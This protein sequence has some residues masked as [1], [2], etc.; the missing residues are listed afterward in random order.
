MFYVGL[1]IGVMI[2][3]MC[4]VAYMA[5]A[6]AGKQAYEMLLPQIRKC[7]EEEV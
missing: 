6:I 1:A 5:L 7:F 2:G 3:G 4:G